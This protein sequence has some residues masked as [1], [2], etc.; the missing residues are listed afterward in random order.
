MST[1]WTTSWERP[2]RS[3]H[4]GRRRARATRWP[5]SPGTHS[6]TRTA[7]RKSRFRMVMPPLMAATR[8]ATAGL[9]PS[10]LI[11][12][13][14]SRSVPYP[15]A[16]AAIPTG[17]A[18]P[19]SP[20]AAAS[21][22]RTVDRGGAGRHL[23]TPGNIGSRN[24]ATG[25]NSST[26]TA[27]SA[28]LT[29][30]PASVLEPV[31]VLPV[32][33]LLGQVGEHRPGVVDEDLSTFQP[34]LHRGVEL[35]PHRV[36]EAGPPPYPDRRQPLARPCVQFF[37]QHVA[38]D[39]H[40]ATVRILHHVGER[41]HPTPHGG[42]QQERRDP[43]TVVQR[44][45]RPTGDGGERVQQ[46]RGPFPTDLQ[47]QPHRRLP[48]EG[49]HRATQLHRLGGRQRILLRQVVRPAGALPT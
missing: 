4:T 49:G 33:D 16:W 43:V 9:L 29:A 12:W 15:S 23:V 5:S 21:R 25:A 32:P 48:P 18:Y 17:G 6:T 28:S 31:V 42:E 20:T 45:L 2:S 47:R 30:L 40:P 27:G 19:S 44:L 36:P 8:P 39:L 46:Q 10:L 1:T 35:F 26:R 38:A 14:V 11:G 3:G 34:V 37:G 41:A 7:A 13:Y 22:P 24:E